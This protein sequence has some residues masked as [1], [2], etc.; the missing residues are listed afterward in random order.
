MPKPSNLSFFC[1]GKDKENMNNE[2]KYLLDRLQISKDR[3]RA[4]FGS[5]HQIIHCIT[6]KNL[7]VFPIELRFYLNIFL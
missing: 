7:S 3:I 1:V 4:G 5:L 2:K 6:L